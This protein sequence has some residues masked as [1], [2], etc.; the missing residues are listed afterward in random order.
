MKIAFLG[1]PEFAVPTLHALYKEGHELIVCTAPDKPVGRHAILTPPPVKARAL[2]W[3]LP[4]YQFE[5]IRRPEGLALLHAFSPDCVVTAAFGQLLS[6]ANL[7]IPP[8]GTINVHASLLPKYRGA[9]PIQSAILA[10]ERVTGITTMRTDIGMDTGAILLQTETEI[11]A[12]ETAG[13]LSERLSHIGAT[14][15]VETLR[16]LQAGDL[17]ATAQNDAAASLC[18]PLKKEDGKLCF[19]VSM[20]EVHDKVRGVNPWPGAF[21]LLDGLPL[22]IWATLQSTPPDLGEICEQ[23][24]LWGDAKAGLFVRCADG[25]LEIKELQAQGGKRMDAK[26]FLRGK[27][28]QGKVLQ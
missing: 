4:V 15:L 20:Q 10:G 19:S 9:S 23:G 26:T 12:N 11:G 14:L 7:D 1:T 6:Q 18:K 5:R 13:E 28:L 8:L 2:E 27:P 25:L 16:R 24:A 3:G 17:Q 22:K 21:A